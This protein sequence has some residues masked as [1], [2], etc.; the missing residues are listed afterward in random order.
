LLMGPAGSGK[1]TV[2]VMYAVSA[3]ERGD[4]AAIFAFDESIATLI[5]RCDSLGINFKQGL[6]RG[7]VKVKSID[8]AEMSP[9]EFAESVRESVER[10]HAKLVV[11]DSLNGYSNA[12]P[13]EQYLTAHLHELLSYLGRNGVTTLMVMAQRGVLGTDMKSPVDTSYLA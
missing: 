7:Q 5:L 13:E 12:M 9:G 4:H 6:E 11:I 8:P 2:A 3:A 1:S 10:D